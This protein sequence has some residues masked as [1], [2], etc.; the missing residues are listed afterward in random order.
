MAASELFCRVMLLPSFWGKPSM[1]VERAWPDWCMCFVRD[2]YIYIYIYITIYTH[3][4]GICKDAYMYTHVQRP[5]FRDRVGVFEV[6]T[7]IQG[8]GSGRDMPLTSRPGCF[9]GGSW[10]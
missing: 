9:T 8:A 2:I 4:K 1:P 3:I 7:E 5:L 6:E 10:G